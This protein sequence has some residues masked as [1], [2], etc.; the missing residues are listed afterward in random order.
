MI[1]Y[2]S[3][4]AASPARASQ[5]KP[6]VARHPVG[7][8]VGLTRGRGTGTESV[9]QGHCSLLPGL[10]EDE[11]RDRASSRARMMRAVMRV[12]I[13]AR[14]GGSGIRTY[15]DQLAAGL[16]SLSHEVTVLDETTSEPAAGVVPL[17]QPPQ[18]LLGPLAGW[19][20]PRDRPAPRTRTRR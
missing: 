12:L 7:L 4:R 20:A 5:P 19:G 3:P 8:G 9:G 11:T 17:A 15:T 14:R 10:G 13:A 1:P 16:A 18:K 6:A 2:T